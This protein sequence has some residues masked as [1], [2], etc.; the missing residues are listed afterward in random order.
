[1][2]EGTNWS[3]ERS[4]VKEEPDSIV[5]VGWV[6]EEREKKHSNFYLA[7]FLLLLTKPN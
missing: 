3:P 2:E 5:I 7:L 4:R 6:K 1:M